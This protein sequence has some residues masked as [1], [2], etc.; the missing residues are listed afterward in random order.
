[1]Q[2]KNIF[3]NIPQTLREELFE[4]IV[5]SKHVKIERII[6]DGHTS[7]KEGWYD[8][9]QNEWVIV[10]QGEAILSFEN[11]TNVE[12]K[13]GDYH[14]IPAHKRHKVSHTSQEEKTIWLAVYY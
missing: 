13:R 12:L 4:E 1:M 3:K 8:S 14:N 6:S 5:T 2:E 9:E 10:L 11:G 7:P